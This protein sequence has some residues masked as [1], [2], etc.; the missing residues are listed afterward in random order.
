MSVLTITLK[1]EWNLPEDSSKEKREDEV[2]GDGAPR[3]KMIH[4]GPEVCLQGQLQAGLVHI[5]TPDRRSITTRIAMV[6]Q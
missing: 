2:E 4:P 6:M 3:D 1:Y 5:N